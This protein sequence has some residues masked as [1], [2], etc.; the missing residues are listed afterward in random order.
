MLV[1][2]WL[3]A[4]HPSLLTCT[5]HDLNESGWFR[6]LNPSLGGLSL[7]L[8]SAFEETN[9]NSPSKEMAKGAGVKNWS[10]PAWDDIIII[11]S[12]FLSCPVFY[13]WNCLFRS[14]HF[15]N[16]VKWFW[17]ML[18]LLNM[19]SFTLPPMVAYFCCPLLEQFWLSYYAGI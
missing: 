19:I 5:R 18:S 9:I 11:I 1:C 16:K 7:R 12:S 13:F 6:N 2:A 10:Q 14:I 4:D 15:W 3:N 17:T 8:K